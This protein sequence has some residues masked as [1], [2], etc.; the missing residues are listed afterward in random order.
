MQSNLS[1]REIQ[2]KFGFKKQYCDFLINFVQGLILSETTCL[3]RVSGF[4]GGGTQGANTQRMRRFLSVNIFNMVELAKMIAE[5]TGLLKQEKMVVI[6]DRT[7]W[8][9]GESHLNFLCLSAYMGNTSIPLV[10]DLLSPDEQYGKKG[11]SGC[12]ERQRVL[13]VFTDAFGKDKIDVI[14]GDREFI[15]HD[16]MNFLK[17]EGIPFVQRLKESGQMI[18]NSRGEMVMAKTIFQDLKVGEV[19]NLGERKI[20]K[21]KKTNLR[22]HVSG[23]RSDKGDL[24]IV[25]HTHHPNPL[26]TYRQRWGI[27]VSF[28]S[29]K[30]GGFGI[31]D[32]HVRNS[33][34]ISCLMNIVILIYGLTVEIGNAIEAV[35][36]RYRRRKNHGYKDK[37]LIRFTL[38]IIKQFLIPYTYLGEISKKWGKLVCPPHI[39][40]LAGKG[41]VKIK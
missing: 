1:S 16:W 4:L 27:E 34:R 31:E 20:G 6:F 30:S 33:K 32:T 10:F 13:K 39:A 41:K 23:T 9:F 38:D 17:E 18:S 21:D 5:K 29:L 14:L 24:V 7:Y 25:A 2:Q 8:Q 15:G 37:T 11:H 22:L 40:E 35:G 12:S 28:R 26:E 19:R 3:A 36:K